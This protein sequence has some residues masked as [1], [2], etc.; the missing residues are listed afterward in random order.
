MKIWWNATWENSMCFGCGWVPLTYYF[1]VL[2]MCD[3]RKPTNL[4]SEHVVWS[5]MHNHSIFNFFYWITHKRLSWL[6]YLVWLCER[7]NWVR[8]LH[9]RWGEHGRI[10]PWFVNSFWQG[11]HWSLGLKQML[12][13]CGLIPQQCQSI[14]T[15][16]DDIVLYA[17]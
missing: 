10:A 14:A 3:K 9:A 7:V 5:P 17:N 12:F 4:T 13:C 11:G 8:S 2:G 1:F 15:R 16:D 6:V